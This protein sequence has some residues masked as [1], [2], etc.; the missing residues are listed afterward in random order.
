MPRFN[1]SNIILLAFFAI[2]II[3]PII[4][5]YIPASIISDRSGWTRTAIK[6]LLLGLEQIRKNYRS[7]VVL[8]LLATVLLLTIALRLWVC[9][10]ALDTSVTLIGCVMFAVVSN[11]LLIINITPGSLGL[12]EIIIGAIASFTGLNFERGLFAASLD[13][14]FSLL[15][16]VVVGLP[17]LAVLKRKKL[18]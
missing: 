5:L 13:R 9:F 14:V 12:R 16:A 11:L 15:F 10:R 6:D 8:F 7:V 2:S 3:L 18:L 1:T 17:G 4:V